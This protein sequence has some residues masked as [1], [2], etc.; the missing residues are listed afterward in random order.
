MYLMYQYISSINT[1]QNMFIC[2]FIVIDAFLFAY[3]FSFL[4][5][6]VYQIVQQNIAAASTKKY[7]K[8]Y[9]QCIS[10]FNYCCFFMTAL[11]CEAHKA[12]H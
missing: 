2:W 7:Y 4:E 10:A 5:V 1:K 8:G 9:E 3:F 11:N 12:R 6:F